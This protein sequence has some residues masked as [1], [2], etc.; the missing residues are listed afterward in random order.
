MQL[1]C[2]RFL[3]LTQ[4]SGW[5]QWVPAPHFSSAFQIWIQPFSPL[6]P[7]QLLSGL[8]C[9]QSSFSD[10]TAQDY[11]KFVFLR[12]ESRILLFSSVPW[13]RRPSL[14]SCSWRSA[15]IRGWRSSSQHTF[16]RCLNNKES[17]LNNPCSIYLFIWRGMVNE[18]NLEL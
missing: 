2:F 7:V 8:F 16:W 4:Q 1:F 9:F 10:E 5:S 17:M 6:S 15:S 3:G 12:R 14:S 18:F 11:W 13:L